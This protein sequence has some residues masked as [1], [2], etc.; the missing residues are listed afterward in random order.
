MMLQPEEGRAI[1]DLGGTTLFPAQQASC[2]GFCTDGLNAGL[3]VAISALPVTAPD[4]LYA[5]PQL[6]AA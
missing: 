2:V 1:Q 6:S 3:L 4:L 5:I